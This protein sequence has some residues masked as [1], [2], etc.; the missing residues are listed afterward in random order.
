MSPLRW[1]CKSTTHLAAELVRQGP[2]YYTQ[3]GAIFRL[4]P[5]AVREALDTQAAS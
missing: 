1:T 5:S 2:V 3:V 4:A